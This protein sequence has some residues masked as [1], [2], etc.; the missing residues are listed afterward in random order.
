M[1]TKSSSEQL[2]KRLV[3]EVEQ[4]L[5]AGPV[6]L[7]EF[8]WI[9]RMWPEAKNAVH[10]I[11]FESLGELLSRPECKL[12]WDKWPT[13]KP[14]RAEL[15]RIEAIPADQLWREPDNCS[16]FLVISSDSSVPS[17]DAVGK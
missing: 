13:Q 17:P 9:L 5:D 14:L 2:V 7:Y 8:I 15:R 1:T 10:S 4:L 11:A 3:T 6:G 16:E 12:K